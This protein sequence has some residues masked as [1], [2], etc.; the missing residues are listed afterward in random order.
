VLVADRQCGSDGLFPS[1]SHF[2][3]LLLRIKQKFHFI[4]F[5][6]TIWYSF[7]LL[8]F[9]FFIFCRLFFLFNFISH[10]LV[11]FNFYIKFDPYS[12]N[13]YLFIYFFIIFLIEFCFSYHS[14]T[15]DFDLFLYQIW[16]SFFYCY[17]FFFCILFLLPF[18]FSQFFPSVFCD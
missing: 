8:L 5:L 13:F 14:S 17:L 4:C 6:Y 18:F 11:S 1:P 12:F 16:S 7:F 15:F 10:H 2:L 3:S 9:F